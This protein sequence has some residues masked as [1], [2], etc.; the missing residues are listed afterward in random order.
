MPYFG[1]CCCRIAYL[2]YGMLPIRKSGVTN[3]NLLTGS[4]IQKPEV[5][6]EMPEKVRNVVKFT[7]IVFIL[8]RNIE[9]FHSFH[10]V[11]SRDHIDF[12]FG[13]QGAPKNF[14]RIR[15]PRQ[16]LVR[17]PKFFRGR[18]PPDRPYLSSGGHGGRESILGARPPQV[19]FFCFAL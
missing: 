2:W 4:R 18:V 7:V 17:F 15:F 8:S 9:L 6:S 14:F 19:N 12:R 3:L 13:R 10:A 1:P 16:P 11:W 5:L